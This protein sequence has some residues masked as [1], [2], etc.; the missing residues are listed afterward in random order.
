[1]LS[2][3]LRVEVLYANETLANHQIDSLGLVEL[4]V[5]LEENINISVDMDKINPLQTLE[6]F[7]R[8]LASC[9]ERSGANLDELI[10][11][12]PITTKVT[13]F[14]NPISELILLLV[15]AVSSLCWQLRV[16]HKERMLPNNAIIIANHQ[17]VLD[18][19]L[20]LNLIPYALR[21]NVFFIGKKELSLLRFPFAGAPV[22]FVDRTGNIVPSLKAAADILRSGHSLIIF[23]EGT[24]TRNG[25]LG[26]FKSGAAYL[27]MHLNK[28]IIPVTIRGAFE[29]MPSGKFL[30]G[31]ISEQKLELIVENEINPQN[32]TSVE[33]LTDH[34]RDVII[35]E[36]R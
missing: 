17:S 28:K 23:P 20:L 11:H 8:Y 14:P 36:H 26:K 1:V 24:R 31:F 13:T 2:D 18:P 22:L 15:R 32:F 3:K 35:G 7:V 25:A 34:L 5:H 6:E 10:L 9:E 16:I 29:I 30:P 27:A 12:G 21:K 4:I 33:A 19:P